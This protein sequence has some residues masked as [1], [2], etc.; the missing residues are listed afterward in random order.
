M[1]TTYTN[2]NRVGIHPIKIEATLFLLKIE[3]QPKRIQQALSHYTNTVSQT[4]LN[5][6]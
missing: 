1:C 3:Q 2:D 5:Q 4:F 6:Y